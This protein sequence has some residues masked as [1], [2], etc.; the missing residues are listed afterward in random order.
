MINNT[1]FINIFFLRSKELVMLDFDLY[2]YYTDS[3]DHHIILTFKGALSQEI[4]VEIGFI[5][6]SKLVVDKQIKKIFAVF[7]EMAQNIM[8]Y[9]DEKEFDLVSGKETGIGIILFTQD[10]NKYLITS[11][12]IVLNEKIEKIV[13]KLEFVNS[14]DNDGLKKAFNE[15]IRSPRE[16]ES[17]GAGLG[18][19]E[20]ARKCSGKIKYEVSK[21]NE[22]KSF[23]VLTIAFDKGN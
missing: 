14:L 16:S 10:K 13:N 19:I 2:K 5:I 4:V 17:K 23:L 8:H 12:N 11:G 7:V 21:I 18:F 1:H 15:Q 9:S 3:K 20:I 22:K 6:K